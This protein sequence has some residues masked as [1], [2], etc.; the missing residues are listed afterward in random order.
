MPMHRKRIQSNRHWKRLA[1]ALMVVLLAMAGAW[2]IR[3][4]GLA[5][6]L[7]ALQPPPGAKPS[8]PPQSAAPETE[9]A[10]SPETKSPLN[11]TLPTPPASIDSSLIA[12][13]G[14]DLTPQPIDPDD[15]TLATIRDLLLERSQQGPGAK[16]DRAKGNILLEGHADPVEATPSSK[17]WLAIESILK[18]ARLLEAEAVASGQME[19][20]GSLGHE[21]AAAARQLRQQARRL[22][23]LTP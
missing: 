18:G 19:I 16:P 15:P 5:T 1:S 11:G 22:I 9:L 10:T 23:L 13:P 4:G 2:E 14:L 12:P 3:E 21:Q 7:L 8:G 20:P 17:H 6:Q